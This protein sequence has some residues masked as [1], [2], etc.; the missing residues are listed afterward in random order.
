MKRLCVIGDPVGHSLSPLIHNAA[1]EHLG[2]HKEFV[3][4]KHKVSAQG[5]ADFI[6]LVRQK[7]FVGLSVTTPHKNTI[8]PLLDDLSE[9]AKL[10]GAVNTVALNG[11]RLIGHNTDGAGCVN[12]LEAAKAPINGQVIVLLG[13][14]GAAGA[15]AVSLCMQGAKRLY[16]LNRT[17]KKAKALA[18]IAR[19]V[20]TTDI[21]AMDLDLIEEAL[22]YADILINATTVGMKG[23]QKKTIVPM[24]SIKRNMT[25][26]D[27][28][29]DPISTPLINDAKR[30][31]ARAIIG[32]EMLLQQGAL[33]FGLFTGKDAPMDA[34]RVALR[35]KLEA[36]Q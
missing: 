9:E 33:Q 10:A 25:V 16:I 30:I 28:V 13:A 21:Y 34:M 12:A 36:K 7:E 20:S 4:E 8:I 31:G 1:L 22:A 3:F 27:L 18:E 2:L 32:I 15:I 14:G 11:D 24:S 6:K 19:K 29:Y 35:K 5:L 17:L 26:M 23:S